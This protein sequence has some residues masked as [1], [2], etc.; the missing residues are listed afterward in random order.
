[1]AEKLN[2]PLP[3]VKISRVIPQNPLNQS[4][5]VSNNNNNSTVTHD[6]PPEIPAEEII[7]DKEK[8]LV[9]EGAFGTVYK[10]TCRGISVAIKVPK[11]QDLTE[12]ELTQFREEVGIM[13]K[14]SNP[15]VVLFL[16][17]C[18]DPN[19]LMIVTELMQSDLDKIIHENPNK[20]SLQQAVGYM[21][22]TALVLNWL[23]GICKIVH[24]DLKPANL[25]IDKNHNVRLTDFGFSQLKPQ[26]QQ[27]HDLQGPKGTAIYMAPE[28][29]RQKQFGFKAD[30]YSFGLIMYEIIT[31]EELFSEYSDWD[32]FEEAICERNE[33]PKDFPKDPPAPAS[34][35]NLIKRCWA[36]D[37]DE[38]PEFDEILFRL[39]EIIVDL[40]T[41]NVP[42]K[43]EARL[44]W[45]LNFLKPTNTLREK[46]R[47][48]EFAQVLSKETKL[49]PAQFGP[50]YK[51]FTKKDYQNDEE[52]EFEITLENFVLA[53]HCFGLFFI[54][55]K[56]AT[57]LNT[58]KELVSQP[59]FH[60]DIDK[61]VAESR[62]YLRPDA[63]FL[64]RTSTTEP[65]KP[66]TVSKITGKVCKH[67]RITQLPDG[68]YS[69]E[70]GPKKEIKN[71]SS[72][73]ELQASQE[74]GLKF[75]CPTIN[76]ND[77]Y[78]DQ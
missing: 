51:F 34:L 5:A 55:E 43:E 27:L 76:D 52:N 62:L 11:K 56:A 42:H 45:K 8:D 77:P 33:R 64:I 9:G 39:D 1:M 4:S 69:I 31:G 50:L 37:P 36:S 38:R 30:V 78:T 10:G 61:K 6:G 17:A 15:N 32:E 26:G 63:T 57:Y 40:K 35:I 48:T 12:E 28:V 75:A 60:G 25:L 46:I 53:V 21:K 24:R 65:N 18:T 16:G 54:P 70:V 13:R 49:P 72:I 59:W 71:F 2:S 47:W 7:F 22:G 19:N 58:L 41:Q 67:K 14:I 68:G 74:V 20:I 3:F 29:M 66:F 73:M 44:F 23:H